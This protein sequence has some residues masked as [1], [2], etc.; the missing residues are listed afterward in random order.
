MSKKDRLQGLE[1]IRQGLKKESKILRKKQRSC[2]EMIEN[3]KI[4]HKAW[5]R[6][7]TDD[8]KPEPI[9]QKKQNRIKVLEKR[10]LAFQKKIDEKEARISDIEWA[11]K[12][13]R[14]A[15]I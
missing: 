8:R 9:P 14:V 11:I 10:I 13:L 5:I 6:D 7:L 12:C 1:L 15:K 2:V 4:K 3:I